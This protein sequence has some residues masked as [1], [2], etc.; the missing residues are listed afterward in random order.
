[1]PQLYP[2]KPWLCPL[3]HSV[4]YT[5]D[6][7]ALQF[8][9]QDSYPILSPP[10]SLL[11]NKHNILNTQHP[12]S[13]RFYHSLVSISYVWRNVFCNPC[14]PQHISSHVSLSVT[15]WL[16]Q[17]GRRSLDRVIVKMSYH[18]SYIMLKLLINKVEKWILQMVEQ[19]MGMEEEKV[20]QW[21]RCYKKGGVD[22]R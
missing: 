3:V 22:L 5:W 7:L 11:W 6:V 16:V 20:V 9:S 14:S 10:W 13:G 8:N 1:M 18:G 15:G 12:K 4:I 21:N 17:M 19:L 2:T